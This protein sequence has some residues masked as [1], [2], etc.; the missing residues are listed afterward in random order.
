MM[1]FDIA[2]MLSIFA[3][4]CMAGYGACLLRRAGW[5]SPAEVNEIVQDAVNEAF[6]L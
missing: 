5:F 4:G 1:T 6:G 3:L 2:F